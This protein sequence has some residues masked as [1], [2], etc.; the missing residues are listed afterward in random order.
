VRGARWEEID[1]EA[2]VWTIP[3]G[4]MKAGQ[5]HRVPLCSDA[6][7]LLE[8]VPRFEGSPYIFPGPRGGPIS[9]MT[10]VKVCRALGVDAVPH[11]FRSSFRD[12]CSESTNYPRELAEKALAHA[13]RSKVEAAYQRGDLFVKRAKLM[14]DWA[15]YL[16]KPAI[17][18]TVTPIRGAK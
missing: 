2:R 11:G 12:W 16:R 15:S 4:R 6:L 9:D 10:I 1:L 13:L 3:A 7:Y 14:G 17:P 8:K 5:E 18:A